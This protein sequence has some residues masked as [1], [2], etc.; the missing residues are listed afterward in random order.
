MSLLSSLI[1]C[2]IQTLKNQITIT[3]K[4][5]NQLNSSFDASYNGEL[6]TSNIQTAPITVHDTLQ[7]LTAQSQHAV[8]SSPASAPLDYKT[9]KV[10]RVVSVHAIESDTQIRLSRGEDD[11]SAE[12]KQRLEDELAFEKEWA[13][14]EVRAFLRVY[15]CVCV[16][17][18]VCG[19]YS[20]HP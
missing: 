3:V 15:V 18:F 9:R 17:V 20:S 5:R 8:T 7:S 10:Q 4:R 16:L 1:A 6:E 12:E 19:F 11:V 2:A 13:Q 14:V